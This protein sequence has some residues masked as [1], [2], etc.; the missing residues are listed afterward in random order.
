MKRLLVLLS[1]GLVL[2]LPSFAKEVDPK[3]KVAKGKPELI[4]QGSEKAFCPVCAMSVKHNYKTSHGVVAADAKDNRQYCSVRCVLVD[5]KH[6]HEGHKHV[7]TDA[8]TEK[9]IDAATATYVVGSKVPGTMSKVSKIGFASKADAESFKADFGGEIMNYDAMMAAAQ[10]SLKSDVA[11]LNMKKKKMM[12]PMGKKLYKASCAPIKDFS[13][14]RR[15]NELKTDIMKSKICQPEI[16][17]KK[18]QMVTLYLWEVKRLGK[19]I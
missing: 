10:D 11:M 15:I 3:F 1:L 6:T 7:V 13:K 5:G 8:K 16:K 9:L 2:S 18:L 17:M 12:Y 19:S 14:Y 4:Q